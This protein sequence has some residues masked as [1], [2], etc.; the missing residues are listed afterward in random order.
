MFSASFAAAE[1]VNDVIKE[2]INIVKE[3]EDYCQTDAIVSKGTL[4]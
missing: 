1:H 3:H 4:V 2:N